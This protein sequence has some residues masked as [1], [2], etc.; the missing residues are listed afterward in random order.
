MQVKLLWKKTVNILVKLV[1]NDPHLY[2]KLN[3]ALS[4]A[5]IK[6]VSGEWHQT[7][8]M[9]TCYL[10]QSFI[11]N[12]S[13]QKCSKLHETIITRS[14]KGKKPM[15]PVLLM[16]KCRQTFIIIMLFS[17]DPLRTVNFLNYQTISLHFYEQLEMTGA[18]I[19][20]SAQ[21]NNLAQW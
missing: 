20:Y 11:Q 6:T 12:K 5:V 14:A 17:R 8:M 4:W 3:T 2:Y 10:K 16:C 9:V 13:L 21:R 15:S 7:K 19:M 1:S 18:C